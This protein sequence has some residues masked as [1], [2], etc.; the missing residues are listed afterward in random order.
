M[1]PTLMGRWQTRLLLL[2]TVGVLITL[3]FGYLFSNFV[4]PLALLGYVLL[5]GFV[6]DML[7]N[8]LQ[9]L[10]W[11]RDWPPLFFVAAGI[12]EGLFLWDL[13]QLIS[14]P[15]VSPNL[16]FGQFAAHYG[17]VFIFTLSIMLGP[18]KVVF[19]K[20]RFRGGQIV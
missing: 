17:A 4:T 20:W 11:D 19:L 1:T 14:L 16:S 5:L 6:W 13:I 10:R 8:A 3:F 2:S 18:L 9:S 12:V 15:G 7:Y